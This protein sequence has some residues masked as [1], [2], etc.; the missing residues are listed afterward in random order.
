MNQRILNQL[1]RQVDRVAQEGVGVGREARGVIEAQT[2]KEVLLLLT[3][4]TK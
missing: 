4:I 2:W 3:S 1:V